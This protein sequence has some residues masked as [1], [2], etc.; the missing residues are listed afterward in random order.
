MKL[1]AKAKA[2]LYKW[3]GIKEIHINYEYVWTSGMEMQPYSVEIE[4]TT[5]PTY[6]TLER[7]RGGIYKNIEKLERRLLVSYALHGATITSILIY[8]TTKG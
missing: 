3:L 4:E 5:V 7:V 2:Q 1:K 6:Q 8:F